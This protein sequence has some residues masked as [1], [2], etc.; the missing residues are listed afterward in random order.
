MRGALL[1]LSL[2]AATSVEF[3]IYDYEKSPGANWELMTPSDFTTHKDAFIA[4]YNKNKGVKTIKVFQSGN[5]C[6]A[7]K[8][9]KKLTITGT[10]YGYQFPAST[11]GGIRC[12]PTGA[13]PTCSSLHT[14]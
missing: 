11:S 8:G 4:S 5:C 6:F 1:A 2:I 14:R 7:V 10:P 13:K 12:N 9:G 3:G